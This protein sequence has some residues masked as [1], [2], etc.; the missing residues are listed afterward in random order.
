MILNRKTLKITYAGKEDLKLDNV[1][2]QCLD[3]FGFSKS[4]ESYDF[5]EKEKSIAFKKKLA[6][7]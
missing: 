1:L 4:F 6:T 3:E 5:L 7:E 2:I